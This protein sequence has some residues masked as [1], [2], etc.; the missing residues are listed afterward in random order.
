MDVDILILLVP[1]ML[2]FSIDDIISFTLNLSRR[3]DP[4]YASLAV[5]NYSEL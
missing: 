1:Y 3:T 5:I 2:A 4:M